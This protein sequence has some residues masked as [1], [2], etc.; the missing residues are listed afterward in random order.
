MVDELG[1]TDQDYEDV[2]DTIALLIT[3]GRIL[4]S[5]NRPVSSIEELDEMEA[6]T[7]DESDDDD[8]PVEVFDFMYYFNKK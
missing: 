8:S 7:I 1:L 5:S 2:A 3:E 6:Y 4:D